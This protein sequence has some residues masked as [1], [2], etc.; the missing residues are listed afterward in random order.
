MPKRD[1]GLSDPPP[2]PPYSGL[3]WWPPEGKLAAFQCDFCWHPV[4]ALQSSKPTCELDLH[5]MH[6]RC[7]GRLLQGP[8]FPPAWLQGCV[9]CNLRND[10]SA[11]KESPDAVNGQFP[12]SLCSL[13]RPESAI[14]P[15]RCVLPEEVHAIEECPM[16]PT[17]LGCPVLR[18]CG[19]DGCQQPSNYAVHQR[20]LWGGR[21]IWWAPGGPGKSTRGP[22]NSD[23]D[24]TEEEFPA[25]PE[26]HDG[27][28]G[29]EFQGLT[30]A[31]GSGVGSGSGSGFG[32]GNN[33]WYDKTK[34]QYD[35][36]DSHQDMLQ[37][38]AEASAI[39]EEQSP[40]IFQLSL[41]VLLFIKS[42]LLD[43][44]CIAFCK[45]EF[46]METIN[47]ASDDDLRELGLIAG[48]ISRYKQQLSVSCKLRRS[49]YNHR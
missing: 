5:G 29:D 45:G 18:R 39:H 42:S 17:V 37:E 25:Q 12:S 31:N 1:L 21:Q 27:T 28:T 14:L 2:A 10:A 34:W 24:T 36:M 8:Y 11:W 9:Y 38:Q 49:M 33:Q 44:K 41:D 32:S 46:T 16:R 4:K 20:D 7:H 30:H 22:P 13:C 48:E 43:H 47:M 3:S 40:P 15:Q 23:D 19:V 26:D 6:R 35:M